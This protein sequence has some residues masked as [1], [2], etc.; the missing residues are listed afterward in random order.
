[1]R[2]HRRFQVLL[3]HTPAHLSHIL[4]ASACLQVLFEWLVEHFSSAVP[5][6]PL[7]E[8]EV[9]FLRSLPLYLAFSGLVLSLSEI[10]QPATCAAAPTVAE[11]LG[12]PTALPGSIE[13]HA[14]L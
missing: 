7:G 14:C 4:P 3:I 5:A 10:Q 11:L 13:V 8:G 12:S 1:M 2:L 6:P 9:E